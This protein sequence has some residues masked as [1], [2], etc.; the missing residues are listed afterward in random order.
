MSVT[1]LGAAD[2]NLAERI[3]AGDAAAERE[4]FVR[5]QGG[6][7]AVIVHVTG[8]L[9][10]AEDLSQETFV[11]TLKRL[12]A[13]A[14][15]EPAK[16]AAFVAQTARNLAIV[17]MRKERRRRTDTGGGDMQ[18]MVDGSPSQEAH[19]HAEGCARAIRE[20]LAELHSDRDREIL[21]RHYLKDEDK[22][23]ICRELGISPPTFNVVLHRAR[24]RF[25][26]I[27]TRRGIGREDVMGPLGAA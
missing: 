14:L 15:E 11:V 12:R 17:H 27:L 10:A 8:S 16:L 21:T 19:V 24:Q 22:H 20:W 25:L 23:V 6:V 7:R 5:F 4:L 1:E 26:E 13:D 18:E 9:A 2:S 3:R